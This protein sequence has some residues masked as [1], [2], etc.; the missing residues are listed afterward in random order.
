MDAA[1][2]GCEEVSERLY[3]EAGRLAVEP[4][5][6]AP[7]MSVRICGSKSKWIRHM[8]SLCFRSHEPGSGGVNNGQ[9]G[10]VP[11]VPARFWRRIGL[12]RRHLHRLPKSLKLSLNR[13]WSSYGRFGAVHASPNVAGCLRKTTCS[14]VD[15]RSGDPFVER[16]LSTYEGAPSS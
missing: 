13:G 5:S 11:S 1:I 7:E 12:R 14:N 6:N 2:L 3:D 8:Q 4:T 15:C 10:D 9:K 16:E